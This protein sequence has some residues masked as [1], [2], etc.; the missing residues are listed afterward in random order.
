MQKSLTIMKMK[1]YAILDKAKR[2]TE[3]IKGLNLTAV[4][5]Y[6]AVRVSRPGLANL[7]DLEGQI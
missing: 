7:T 3:N 5:I 1:M 6:T 2:Y 4:V